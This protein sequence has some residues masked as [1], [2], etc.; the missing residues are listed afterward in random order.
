LLE[1]EEL[2]RLAAE[3]A[4][5]E[6]KKE[7]WRIERAKKQAA[8]NKQQIEDDALIKHIDK[9]QEEVQIKLSLHK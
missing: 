8:D 6:R 4:E 2:K 5:E 7:L 3:H 1:A 9:M